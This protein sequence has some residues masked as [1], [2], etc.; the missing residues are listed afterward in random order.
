MWWQE[1]GF[2]VNRRA[3]NRRRQKSDLAII[4]LSKEIEVSISWTLLLRQKSH[5]NKMPSQ[6]QRTR[7]EIKS[8]LTK[9]K[10]LFGEK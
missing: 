7:K 3:K 1:I 10:T 2:S 6:R 5:V 8:P 4:V 9:R